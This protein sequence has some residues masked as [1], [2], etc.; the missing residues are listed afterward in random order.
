MPMASVLSSTKQ[1]DRPADFP[2]VDRVVLAVGEVDVSLPVG[3]RAFGEAVA[4]A[5]DL[6]L[7]AG[8]ND[9]VECHDGA[10]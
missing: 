6:G 3:G 4:V 1:D 7:R 8:R 10:G 5:Q 2:T 9:V